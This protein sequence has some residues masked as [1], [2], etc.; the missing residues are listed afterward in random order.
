M[1]TN[2][3]QSGHDQPAQTISEDGKL[4]LGRASEERNRPVAV[5]VYVSPITSRAA[6]RW[7]NAEGHDS[8]SLWDPVS[9]NGSHAHA[10]RDEVLNLAGAV[11]AKRGFNYARGASWQSVSGEKDTERP[12]TAEVAVVPTRAYLDLQNRRFGPAPELPEVPGVTFKTAQRG[13]WHATVPDGRTFLLTWTPHLDGDRW[14]VWGGDQHSDL[15]RP[16]TTSM[17]KALFVLRHPS[18]ARS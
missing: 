15:I 18:H 8:P 7:V 10:L 14:I 12:A 3:H 11:L 4:E 2:N 9:L 16:A 13:Q 17:D 6:L 5:R 1:T